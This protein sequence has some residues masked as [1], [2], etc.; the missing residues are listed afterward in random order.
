MRDTGMRQITYRELDRAAGLAA[1]EGRA[2]FGFSIVPPSTK[3]GGDA[4]A[5]AVT[6]RTM[7]GRM[8]M[9]SAWEK[10]IRPSACSRPSEWSRR[11]SVRSTLPPWMRNAPWTD[12]N[13]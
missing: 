6:A 9:F 8:R 2:N 1:E 12:L 11:K 10:S 7:E 3:L 13:I 4:D 5:G